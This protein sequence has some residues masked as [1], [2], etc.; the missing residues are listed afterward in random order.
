MLPRDF[1]LGLLSRSIGRSLTDAERVSICDIL[2]KQKQQN[3][4]SF[5]NLG[6]DFEIRRVAFIRHRANMVSPG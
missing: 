2:R 3:K 4:P 1:G 6:S 5:K